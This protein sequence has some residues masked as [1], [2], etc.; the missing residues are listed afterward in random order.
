MGGMRRVI[1]VVGICVCVCVWLC[2]CVCWGTT[3]DSN[4]LQCD[5][6][7]LV[8]AKGGRSY[9]D[10]NTAVTADTTLTAT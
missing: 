5:I 4:Q 8:T 2:A 7:Q 10:S 6:V 3:G 9:T 1:V